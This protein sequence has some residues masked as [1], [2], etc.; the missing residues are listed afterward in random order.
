MTDQN[1]SPVREARCQC[2]GGFCGHG[3]DPDYCGS[4]IEADEPPEDW[5][6]PAQRREEK[7]KQLNWSRPNLVKL[8]GYEFEE[9][10]PW[11]EIIDSMEAE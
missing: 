6:H 5:T 8:R 7:G 2:C 11:A 3:T 4:C 10:V 9:V 1:T